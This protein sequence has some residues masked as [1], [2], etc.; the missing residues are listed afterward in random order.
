LQEVKNDGGGT[1]KVT[2]S[3]PANAASD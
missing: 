2:S 1:E 3:T